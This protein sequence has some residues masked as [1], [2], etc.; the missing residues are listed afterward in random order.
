MKKKILAAFCILGLF[1]AGCSSPTGSTP[2][3]KE[4]EEFNTI[5]DM[6]KDEKYSDAFDTLFEKTLKAYGNKIEVDIQSKG[7]YETPVYKDG[8]IEFEESKANQDS[9]TVS[10]QQDKQLYTVNEI[11]VD[12]LFISRYGEDGG[13]NAVLRYEEGDEDHNEA[14]LESIGGGT[15]D[16]STLDERQTKLLSDLFKM[17]PYAYFNPIDNPEYFEFTCE[18]TGTGFVLV[19]TLKDADTYNKE[20]LATATDE[21]LKVG[22][23]KLDALNVKMDEFN[24]EIN[25]EGVIQS[26]TNV[27]EVQFKSGDETKSEK[28]SLTTKIFTYD[29][30]KFNTD[31]IDNVFKGIDDDSIK[32]GDKVSMK[33]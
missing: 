29:Y 24:V 33:E 10:F 11:D 15:K 31:D 3:E 32:V 14:I 26:I 21:L 19:I 20:A 17:D 23:S 28:Y 25:N 16:M 9:T 13:K 22:E 4:V 1:A 5:K 2:Q 7:D 30:D 8:K 12:Y 6:I 27:N 18:D